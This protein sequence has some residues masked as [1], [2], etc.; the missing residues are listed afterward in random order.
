MLNTTGEIVR[1]CIDEA[2]APAFTGLDGAHYGVMGGAK[3]FGGV[4][5]FGGIAAADMTAGQAQPQV[6]P[7]VTGFD[8]IF[9]H[10]FRRL[11]ILC[12]LHVFADRHSS[13]LRLDDAH[14]V[15]GATAVLLH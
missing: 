14:R 9:T 3:V 12:V 6:D 4:L 1:G 11:K 13:P 5:V 7:T 15:A 2:P 10:V 8:A